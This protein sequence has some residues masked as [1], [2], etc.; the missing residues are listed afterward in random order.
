MDY[1]LPR[2]FH[3]IGERI[4]CTPIG[5]LG[6]GECDVGL[7]GAGDR[8]GSGQVAG[9]GSG[10][11]RSPPAL[12]LVLPALV[13]RTNARRISTRRLPRRDAAAP[14]VLPPA[15]RADRQ[16]CLPR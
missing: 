7:A 12:G 4:F 16:R 14:L 9:P 10:A 3:P 8:R 15:R 5:A 2:L 1:P 6:G 13:V 11:A